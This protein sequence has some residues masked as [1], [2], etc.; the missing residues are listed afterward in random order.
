MS[1]H[2]PV[3]LKETIEGLNIKPDGIY[4]DLTIGRGGHS[5]AILK[6]LTTGYLIGFD[7]D[8]EAIR[9]SQ[10]NLSKIS[11]RFT[12]IH[13][14][15][16]NLGE[17][18]KQQNISQVDGI[19]MDLGVSSPQFD[20]G[21]RGFSY[22]LDAPLDMRMDQ[23]Q[24]LTAYEIIN[25]Y[26][27]QELE[28]IMR[29]YGEERFALS[30]AKNIAK[31]REVAPIQTTFE[32]ADIIKKSKPSKELKKVGHPAKQVFQAIRIAVNDELNALITG[33][34]EAIPLLRAHGGRLAVI[35]FHSGEDRIVKSIFKNITTTIGNRLDGPLAEQEKEYQL[36][37]RKP[38]V[39][40]EKE[41]ASNPRSQSAKLRIIERK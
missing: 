6:K 30:I 9:E 22:R 12:L 15:F 17:S 28:R 24:Q 11:E 4:L 38:I 8:E 29:E 5:S 10:A 26:S 35:T 2:T 31:Q 32:L 37:T 25:T 18:L 7:Q 1:K 41:I 39:A 21:E 14:N 3:L 34:N 33:L 36:V 40:S 20:E 27:L 19:L 23:R 13:S 16:K